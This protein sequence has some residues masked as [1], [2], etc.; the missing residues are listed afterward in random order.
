[1]NPNASKTVLISY[2]VFAAVLA[3]AGWLHM[4]T[5]LI[6][7]LFGYFALNKLTFYG[8]K[9]LAVLLFL[10]V[11]CVIFSSFAYF[12]REVFETLPQI[13]SKSI[14]TVVQY[15]N[16]HGIDLP[17]DDKESLKDVVLNALGEAKGVVGNFAKIATKEFVILVVG[18]VIAIGIFLNRQPEVVMNEAATLYSQNYALILSRFR[19][20]YQCFETVM[21]AQMIISAINTAA[22]SAFV[23]AFQLPYA[24]VVIPLT[25]ICGLLPIVGNLLSNT[26]IVGIAFT[27]T[28]QMAVWAMIFLL[29]IHKLEY[30]LN[31]KIIGS[32]IRHPMW[33]TLIALILGESAMGIPGIILAPVFLDFL[34][35]E[36]SRYPATDGAPLEPSGTDLDGEP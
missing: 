24:G 30:F 27:L 1:M 36:G 14:P 16:N 23:L 21:G 12:L 32:R 25:F 15:A 5:L 8:R 2:A 26:L 4:A 34:K 3:V 18:V 29:C 13:A 11:V 22:T 17:F 31:S 7:V 9:W 19:S 33:L 6:T 35:V 28:P 20:F 10:I